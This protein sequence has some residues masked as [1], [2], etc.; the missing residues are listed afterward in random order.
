MKTHK[1]VNTVM[2]AIAFGLGLSPHAQAGRLG[3]VLSVGS[4][5]AKVYATG[6]G[7]TTTNAAMSKSMLRVCLSESMTIGEYEPVLDKMQ[8]K[9]TALEKRVERN[10]TIFN[11]ND[12]NVD[13]YSQASVDRYNKSLEN[14]NA[15]IDSYNNLFKKYETIYNRYD[16]A[17]N[18]FNEKCEGR[19][20]YQD[21]YDAVLLSLASE[22]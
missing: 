14:L 7:D 4:N 21:D 20:Y 2:I 18:E 13:E 3:K 8:E 1:K 22:Q 11:H 17:I 6:W 5:V 19:A 10:E 16:S 15:S 9:L 12:E